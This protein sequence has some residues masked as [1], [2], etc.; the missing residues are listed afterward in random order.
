MRR[1]QVTYCFWRAPRCYV[2]AEFK[3]AEN[4][5][6]GTFT[7]EHQSVWHT[8]N[9]LSVQAS[10]HRPDSHRLF[11]NQGMTFG[12]S[13]IG[14]ESDVRNDVPL[15]MPAPRCICN[16]P[17]D[18]RHW[19][20]VHSADDGTNGDLCSCTS[21]WPL[22]LCLQPS[23]SQRPAILK[24]TRPPHQMTCSEQ[25]MAMLRQRRCQPGQSAT[26]LHQQLQRKC[27]NGKALLSAQAPI[28]A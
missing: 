18:H 10:Q 25:L 21:D 11:T 22:A 3:H 19:G 15:P 20:P 6:E 4:L 23:I 16:F 14:C 28:A 13:N 2:Y 9:S 8:R 17:P 12:L 24:G 1:G 27:T 7:T 5:R 26:I